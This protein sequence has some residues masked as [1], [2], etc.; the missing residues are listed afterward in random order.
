[1]GRG[2]TAISN[3][4]SRSGPEK[5]TIFSDRCRPHCLGYAK[6]SH[7]AMRKELRRTEYWREEIGNRRK[8]GD[9]NLEWLTITFVKDPQVGITHYVSMADR[10]YVA[11]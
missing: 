2:F 7:G 11:Q 10:H 3:T 1:M 5:L 8:N 6:V 4:T 9:V